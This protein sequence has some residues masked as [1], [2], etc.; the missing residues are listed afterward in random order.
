MS[1]TWY[2]FIINDWGHFRN[3]PPVL[4]SAPKGAMITK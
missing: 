2:N 3:R 4:P 1:E